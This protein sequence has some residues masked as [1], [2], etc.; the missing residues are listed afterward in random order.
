MALRTVVL[1][2]SKGGVGKT[3]L[4]ACFAVEAGRRNKVALHDVDPQQSLARWY[5]LRDNRKNLVLLSAKLSVA[6]AMA[7]AASGG[8]DFLVVDTP[9]ALMWAIEAAIE[10]RPDLIV[11]PVKPSPID[12]ESTDPIVQLCEQHDVPFVFVVNMATTRAGM[13]AGAIEF[14]S[15]DARTGEPRTVLPDIVMQRQVYMA[16]MASGQSAVEI[17]KTGKVGEEIQP[18][19][20][21]IARLASKA[22]VKA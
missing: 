4:S 16:A 14:L 6:D 22:S 13:T 8:F 21:A 18:I 12:V 3:T 9:P 11:I 10:A 7:K 15:E 1:A 2:C 17:D 20:K 5:E 19:W